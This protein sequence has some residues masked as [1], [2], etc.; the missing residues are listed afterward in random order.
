M[1]PLSEIISHLILGRK[2]F[3]PLACELRGRWTEAANLWPAAWR[4]NLLPPTGIFS[5]L[6]ALFLLMLAKT[7][8]ESRNNPP[9]GLLRYQKFVFSKG[10]A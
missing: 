6:M 9:A 8:C 7:A 3:H 2:F 1:R 4:A 5:L 10:T